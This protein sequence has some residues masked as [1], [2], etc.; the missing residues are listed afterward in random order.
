MRMAHGS[1]H[2]K[3]QVKPPKDTEDID[4]YEIFLSVTALKPLEE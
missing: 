2:A 1:W 3:G 4:V